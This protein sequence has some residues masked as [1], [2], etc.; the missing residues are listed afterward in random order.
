MT[1]DEQLRVISGD[2][3]ASMPQESAEETETGEPQEGGDKITVAQAMDNHL[4][5]LA[6]HTPSTGS[7]KITATTLVAAR[8]L[9]TPPNTPKVPLEL[10]KLQYRDALRTGTS[11]NALARA[12]LPKYVQELK[13]LSVFKA[14][15]VYAWSQQMGL[16]DVIFSPPCHPCYPHWLPGTYLH[17]VTPI[18]QSVF[19]QMTVS[20]AETSN[21][22]VD[23]SFLNDYV[24]YGGTKTRM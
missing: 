8:S 14:D 18:V 23:I 10:L 21:G 6:A 2:Q 1:R 3:S 11:P 17:R 19:E 15:E 4:A 22:G 20:P 24:G 13:S 5:M 9:P 16:G 7:N 12:P